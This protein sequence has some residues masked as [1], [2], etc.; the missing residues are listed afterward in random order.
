MENIFGRK[1]LLL[2]MME[3][4]ETQVNQ[5]VSLVVKVRLVNKEIQELMVELVLVLAEL[6]LNMQYLQVV[7]LHRQVVGVQQSQSGRKENIFGQEV[8]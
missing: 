1:V 3:L 8:V 6:F 4:L 5:L 7:Q 2:I